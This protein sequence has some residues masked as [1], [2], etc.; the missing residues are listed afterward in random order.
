MKRASLSDLAQKEYDLVVAGGG[1][2]G[3]AIARDAALR[4]L[5]VC[6]VEQKDWGFGTSSRSTKLIHGG[7]RY[8]EH[9]NFGL[10][11]ESCRERRRLCAELAPHLVKP[12][13]V[14]LPIYRDD[15]RPAWWIRMG[16]WVYDILSLFQN[17]H[18]HEFLG[19]LKALEEVPNLKKEGLAAG[20][21]TW[22]CQMNDARLN[23]ET[24]LAARQAGA[25]C[26]SRASLL[27]VVQNRPGEMRLRIKDEESGQETE[28]RA[29]ALVNATGPWV[30]RVLKQAA[31]IESAK[32]QPSKGIH[33]VTRPLVTSCG[34][35]VSAHQDKRIFFVLPYNLEGKPAS[36][37]GTTES[38]SQDDPG[39]LRALESEIQYLIEETNRV[40]PGADLKRAD[41]LATYAGMRPLAAPLKSGWAHLGAVSRE[42]ALQWDGGILSITG[43]K[44]T[45]FR[46]LA[47]KAVK[48]AARKLNL[49]LGKNLSRVTR[50]PGAPLD[51]GAQDWQNE[52]GR[53]APLLGR[54]YKLAPD[55]PQW[56]V[57]NYGI[58]AEELLRLLEEKNYLSQRLAPGYPVILAEVTWA[59]REEDAL[60]LTDFFLRR[61][62]LG[63]ALTPDESM[64]L[65]AAREMGREL[66]WDEER[67]KREVNETM[68]IIR[69]EYR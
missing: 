64:S 15:P 9:F 29:K 28:L 13:R 45:T 11:F 33:L 54:R 4:G 27:S 20:A 56:L 40:L 48:E 69:E 42:A 43:G 58:R 32:V 57:S 2:N 6:L 63:L 25:V 19:P 18:A 12:L 59:A 24:V 17:V 30:D 34:L 47:E 61:S 52:A 5:G 50:L 8:L 51:G 7:L 37:I 53:L 39:S 21:V 38:D 68:K 3:A 60:H 66:K 49:K 65:R 46:S 10:V 1:I 67:V 14:M 41:V 22:D 23:L 36:L 35:L 55:I 31:G 62:F 44:Y 16:L 26:R